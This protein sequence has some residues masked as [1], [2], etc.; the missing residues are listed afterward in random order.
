MIRA[1]VDRARFVTHRGKHYTVDTARIYTLPGRAAADLRL[2]FRPEGDRG[3]GPD[4]RRLHHHHARRGAARPRS[5]RGG[6]D[7]PAQA[8]FKVSYAADRR[9]GRRAGTPALGELR[10]AGRARPGPPVAAPLRAGIELVTEEMT[11]RV[12]R[13][14]PRRGRARRGVRAVRRRRLRRDLRGQ[15][16]P[17]LRR[18]DGPLPRRGAARAASFR[19]VDTAAARRSST[20]SPKS[21]RYS[22]ERTTADGWTVA[23]AAVPSVSST[24]SPR[25]SVTLNPVLS[26]ARAAT[27][28]RITTSSG[29][30][31]SS[32]RANQGPQATM[33]PTAGVLWIRRFPPAR[34]GS[35][36]P[37]WSHT[38]GPDQ[39]R[40]PPMPC[41][42]TGG[43]GRRTRALPCPRHR[44]AARPASSG[45]SPY[46]RQGRPAPRPPTDRSPGSLGAPSPAWAGRPRGHPLLRPG[47]LLHGPSSRRFLISVCVPS[48]SGFSAD[49]PQR[50]RATV[51]RPGSISSPFS[52]RSSKLPRTINGPSS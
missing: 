15:H 13:L 5:A 18:H 12:R 7:K 41:R 36:S 40:R 37:H 4:R 28:P 46:R 14:R 50:H 29:L 33:C 47:E 23:K 26:S 22:S 24:A 21:R 25:C 48:H 3:R 1:A 45:P 16:G 34:T 39:G 31:I 52:S 9:R 49:L 42:A 35:A 11:A 2:G 51:A 32:S 19:K 6:G 10:P 27:A 30:T 20:K 43:P 8:G 17:A 38:A 44:R